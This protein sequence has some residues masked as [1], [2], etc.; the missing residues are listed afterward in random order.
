[1]RVVFKPLGLILLLAGIA[2]AV[3]IP[4]LSMN[5][6]KKDLEDARAK[7]ATPAPTPTPGFVPVPFVNLKMTD[8]ERDQPVGWTQFWKDGAG[9]PS[10]ARDTSVFLSAPASLRVTGDGGKA[11]AFQMLSHRGGAVW[12]VKGFVK[13]EGDARVIFLVQPRDE[14]FAPLT[15]MEIGVVGTPTD[16]TPFQKTITLPEKTVHVSI[17]LLVEG[18]GRAWL[19][20]VTVSKAPA[21]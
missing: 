5:G 7:A 10:S 3:L 13:S 17:G 11:Q 14:R 15:V 16:W 4:L 12:A 8:I 1:M 9:K 18:K 2:A 19:D 20:D 21:K 6:M